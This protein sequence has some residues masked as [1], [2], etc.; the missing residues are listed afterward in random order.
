MDGSKR[1]AHSNAYFFGFWKNK[2]IVLYDTL[3]KHMNESEILAVMCHELGHWYYNHT[4]FMLAF[5]LVINI[6]L[7]F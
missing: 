7:I 5:G 3:L 6:Y 4:M 2:Q 1:T